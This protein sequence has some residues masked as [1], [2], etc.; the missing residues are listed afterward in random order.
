[1]TD[2]KTDVEENFHPKMDT[3]DLAKQQYVS[4]HTYMSS[5]PTRLYLNS[6]NHLS[7]LHQL[8]VL[9]NHMHL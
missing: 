1:M 7:S 5:H 4:H 8:N 6:T 2:S 9:Y 3:E